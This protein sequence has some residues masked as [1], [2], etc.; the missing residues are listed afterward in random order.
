MF[1]NEF[2]DRRPDDKMND[3]IDFVVEDST[4]KWDLEFQWEYPEDGIGIS[5]L[6]PVHI[7]SATLPSPTRLNQWTIAIAAATTWQD[8]TNIDI[9]E[10]TYVIH[11]GVFNRSAS[12]S[13]TE[14]AFKGNG[15]DWPVQNIE[16]MYLFER[17]QAWWSKPFIVLP[18][19][20]L[21]GRIYG[22]AIQT[23][24]AGYLGVAIAKRL[25]LI[26]ES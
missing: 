24:L 22:K 20:N 15:K 23:D 11:G 26:R 14:C 8:W 3:A 12:P 10:D 2:S 18:K 1:L 21:T 13:F 5:T 16:Q 6:R 7:E 25:I 17:P 9:D 4:T 19:N